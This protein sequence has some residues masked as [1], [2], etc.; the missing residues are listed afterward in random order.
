MADDTPF[1]VASVA[2]P[3]SFKPVSP[4]TLLCFDPVA[5]AAAILLA[6]RPRVLV[7]K[8]S[9]STVAPCILF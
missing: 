4:E 1:S 7:F 6:L 8:F 2:S 3:A 5:D 9:Y